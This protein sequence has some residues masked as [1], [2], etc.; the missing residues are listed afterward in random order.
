MHGAA[1]EIGADDSHKE[2]QSHATGQE[3]A[4]LE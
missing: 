1:L 3:V 2:Q 4:A